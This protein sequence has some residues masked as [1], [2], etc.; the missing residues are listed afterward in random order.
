[1]FTSIDYTIKFIPACLSDS[2]GVR[3]KVSLSLWR[4]NG[5]SSCLHALL[6]VKLYEGIFCM[7]HGYSLRIST[8]VN[9][10]QK[11]CVEGVYVHVED[12]YVGCDGWLFNVGSECEKSLRWGWD[13]FISDDKTFISLIKET[14]KETSIK[15]QYVCVCVRER[16]RERER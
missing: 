1:M 10:V 13:R 14:Q 4:K 7:R 2:G 5:G 8:K 6:L 9:C 16:E 12:E 11:K 3:V 15:K